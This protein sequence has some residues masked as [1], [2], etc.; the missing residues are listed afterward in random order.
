[1]C[2]QTHG[3]HLRRLEPLKFTSEVW[4]Q[5][6]CRHIRKSSSST[7]VQRLV[8]RVSLQ[9][10]EFLHKFSE[11]NRD[12]WN[13][14][15]QLNFVIFLRLSYYQTGVK[16]KKKFEFSDGWRYLLFPG[17]YL[18]S[19]F[20]DI[21]LHHSLQFLVIFQISIKFKNTIKT[22]TSTEW[23]TSQNNTKSFVKEIMLP[24]QF[25]SISD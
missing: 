10:A 22:Y 11:F 24:P 18:V 19:I 7:W 12:C 13:P 4:R 15:T 9:T 20:Q 14:E 1:M 2:T 23:S 25:F 21:Q 16:G 5:T 3:R 6:I 17:P 8:G